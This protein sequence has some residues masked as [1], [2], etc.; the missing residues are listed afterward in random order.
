MLA[1][2]GKVCRSKCLVVGGGGALSLH[3]GRQGVGVV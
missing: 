1:E 2:N 3:L